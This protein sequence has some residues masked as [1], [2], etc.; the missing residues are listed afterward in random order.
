[1]STLK[2]LDGANVHNE[3]CERIKD[4]GRENKEKLYIIAQNQIFKWAYVI[5]AFYI[6]DTQYK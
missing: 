5:Y 4:S 1:M 2:M 3:M 6:S